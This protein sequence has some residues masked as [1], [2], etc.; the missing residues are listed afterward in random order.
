MNTTVLIRR[1]IA[2]T[3]LVYDKTTKQYNDP[4]MEIY[5]GPARVSPYGIN[6]DLEVGLDPTARRLVLVQVE[7]KDLG[8]ITDDILT[9]TAAENNQ[10]LLQY[11]FDVRGSIGSSL[12]WTTNLVC[13]ADL[14]YGS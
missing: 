11:Q 5:T 10:E 4:F 14:K 13:E 9:V 3:Q 2:A 1:K 6:F 8:I 12:E 7:G